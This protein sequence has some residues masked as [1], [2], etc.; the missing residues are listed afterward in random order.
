LVKTVIL[1]GVPGVGKTTIL[2]ELENLAR[3]KQIKITVLNFGTVMKELFEREGKSIH[4]DD[5]RRQRIEFQKQ[6]QDK[7]A[8]IISNEVKEGISIVDTHMFIRTSS[9]F[10]S[11]LPYHVLMKLKPSLLVLVEASPH[12]IVE[13]RKD[14]KRMRDEANPKIVEFDL[15]W[16]RATASAC[17]VLTGAPVKIINNENGKQRE[18]AEELLKLIIDQFGAE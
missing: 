2:S 15:N 18:A 6:I 17:S 3:E 4:R 10:W 13:R 14:S 5:I 9:G 7:A 11:G 12:E 8:E 16:S 1:T